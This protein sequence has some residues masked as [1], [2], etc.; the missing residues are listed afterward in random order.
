MSAADSHSP[1]GSSSPW[2]RPRRT[3]AA[4]PGRASALTT[5]IGCCPPGSAAVTCDA[6]NTCTVT[7]FESGPLE[8]TCTKPVSVTIAGAVPAAA[9]LPLVKQPRLGAATPVVSQYSCTSPHCVR[10]APAVAAKKQPPSA[11]PASITQVSVLPPCGAPLQPMTT[12]SANAGNP[13]TATRIRFMAAHDITRAGATSC[14]RA[15]R[16]STPR[17]AQ[18]REDLLRIGRRR[19]QFIAVMHAG[20]ERRRHHQRHAAQQAPR[21]SASRF[22]ASAAKARCLGVGR[23]A[24]RASWM[25]T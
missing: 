25:M 17:R 14:R 8:N 24:R 19:I 11:P 3:R 13:S 12:A 6:S 23:T 15:A 1:A 21:G 18:R 22:C 2:T 5:L 7:P 16:S 10:V 4:S 9:G 20:D